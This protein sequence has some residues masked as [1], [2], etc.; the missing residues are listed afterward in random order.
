MLLADLQRRI[1]VRLYQR[2]F[3]IIINTA[4]QLCFIQGDFSVIFRSCLQRISSRVIRIRNRRPDNVERAQQ[5]G[6][7]TF[8]RLAAVISRRKRTQTRIVA[9]ATS[10]LTPLTHDR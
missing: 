7:S 3:V 2:I 9:S 5:T 1:D 8:R 6:Q 4:M 10:H